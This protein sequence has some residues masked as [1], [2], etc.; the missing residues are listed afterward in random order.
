MQGRSAAASQCGN[1]PP[2]DGAAARIGSMYVWY[3]ESTVSKIITFF[4]FIFIFYFPIIRILSYRSSEK[5]P[6]YVYI[7][8]QITYVRT[9]VTKAG[10]MSTSIHYDT[11]SV[12]GEFTLHKKIVRGID[13]LL[14]KVKIL[15]GC[16]VLQVAHLPRT[17]FFRLLAGCCE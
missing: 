17:A 9:S 14:S 5:R 7:A 1:A 2:Y 6:S 16:V 15:K 13:K 11:S 3:T 12:V 10:R 8:V 4:I